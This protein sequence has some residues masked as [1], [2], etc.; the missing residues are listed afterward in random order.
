MIV[1]Y[2]FICVVGQMRVNAGSIKGRAHQMLYIYNHNVYNHHH[3]LG[4]YYHTV[5]IGWP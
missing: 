3:Y 5:C 4:A 1:L 2:N